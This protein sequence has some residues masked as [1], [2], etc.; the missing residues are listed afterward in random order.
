MKNLFAG[1]ILVIAVGA[2][3]Y[4]RGKDDQ[5]LNQPETPSKK[6]PSQKTPAKKGDKPQVAEGERSLTDRAIDMGIMAA[7]ALFDRVQTEGKP[8]AEKLVKAA[9]GYYKQT[10]EKIA[11]LA[12]EA[13]KI[14]LGKEGNEKKKLMLELWKLRTSVNVLSLLDAGVLKNVIGMDP[15]GIT[16]MQ[17]NLKVVENKVVKQK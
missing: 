17:K 10:S 11:E 2:I 1:L 8:L 5:S 16:K 13:D 3:A 4:Q 6:T 14:D 7:K 9:P 12:K 15:S